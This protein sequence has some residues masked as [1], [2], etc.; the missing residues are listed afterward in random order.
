MLKNSNLGPKLGPRR[1]NSFL[2]YGQKQKPNKNIENYYLE[3]SVIFGF[4]E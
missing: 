4:Y 1:Y 2:F 3:K